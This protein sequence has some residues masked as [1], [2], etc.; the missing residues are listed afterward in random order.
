M[1]TIISR[2]GH[3]VGEDAFRE[4]GGTPSSKNRSLRNLEVDTYEDLHHMEAE[5][6]SL[7]RNEAAQNDKH[8]NLRAYIKFW[9]AGAGD[10]S[11]RSELT[12]HKTLPCWSE[13]SSCLNCRCGEPINGGWSR[14]RCSAGQK[15]LSPYR[16]VWASNATKQSY[17][18]TIWQVGVGP[19]ARRA[20]KYQQNALGIDL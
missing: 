15:Q 12:H 20:E 16:I 8:N 18:S 9:A 2:G 1:T 13:C 10:R 5:L 7:Q 11:K 17:L 3:F 14:C 19:V 4:K 6:A